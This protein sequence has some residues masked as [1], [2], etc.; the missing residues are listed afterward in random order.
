V[1]AIVLKGYAICPCLHARL[2]AIAEWWRLAG[3]EAVAQTGNRLKP[4]FAG[5]GTGCGF[6]RCAD[7][8][9][10]LNCVQTPVA[11]PLL[12]TAPSVVTARSLLVMPFARGKQFTDFR[13]GSASW[14]QRAMGL[15]RS[16]PKFFPAKT[17]VQT[18]TNVH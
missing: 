6:H 7:P 8:P 3:G 1:C 2:P 4:Q 18:T 10:R 9:R 15:S 17:R 16:V 12:R 11:R 13:R 5:A 14:S